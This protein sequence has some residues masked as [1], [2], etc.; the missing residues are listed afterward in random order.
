MNATAR[1]NEGGT[2]RGVGKGERMQPETVQLSECAQATGNAPACA[3]SRGGHEQA[4]IYPLA[5]GV[6]VSAC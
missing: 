1:K 5:G 3:W 6:M 4:S 2:K